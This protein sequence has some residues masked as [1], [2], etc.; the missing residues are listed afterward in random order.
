MALIVRNAKNDPVANAT[1][2]AVNIAAQSTSETYSGAFHADSTSNALTP[3]MAQFVP[4]IPGQPY[5]FPPSYGGVAG[6]AQTMPGAIYGA[7]VPQSP[8]VD[9]VSGQVLALALAGA[10]VGSGQTTD[11]PAHFYDA[12]NNSPVSCGAHKNQDSVNTALVGAVQAFQA[13]GGIGTASQAASN[14]FANAIQ[15]FFNAHLQQANVHYTSDGT[16]TSKAAAASSL[17]TFQTLVNDLL[18]RINNHI[19]GV[20]PKYVQIRIIAE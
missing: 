5:A 8:A 12:P 15:T 10:L 14:T 16:N 3:D 4:G 11:P 13:A 20:N 6:N 19:S 17:S 1:A 2:L 7:F 9:L 18:N